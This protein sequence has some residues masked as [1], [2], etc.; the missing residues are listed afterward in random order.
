MVGANV[1]RRLASLFAGIAPGSGHSP[2]N[3][4]ES[5]PHPTPN[6]SWQLSTFAE[7][8]SLENSPGSGFEYSPAVWTDLV[9]DDD[10]FG[11][12]DVVDMAARPEETPL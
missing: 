9:G 7:A 1:K 2:S 5:E 11:A 8:A 6:L 12:D 10:P 4:E 3:G